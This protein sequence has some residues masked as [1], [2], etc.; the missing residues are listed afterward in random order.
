MSSLE[1]ES[2]LEVCFNYRCPFCNENAPTQRITSSWSGAARKYGAAFTSTSLKEDFITYYKV[3][4]T[5]KKGTKPLKTTTL[6]REQ[7][8]SL[9]TYAYKILQNKYGVKKGDFVCHYFSGNQIEDLVFR[10]AE[11]RLKLDSVKLYNGFFVQRSCLVF[12]LSLLIGRLI[13]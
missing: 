10:F 1:T 12:Q 4:E 11:V 2:P 8:L 6:T 5:G 7:F 3:I 13:Q 9:S